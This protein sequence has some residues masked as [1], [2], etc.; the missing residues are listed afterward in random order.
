MELVKIIG[1]VIILSAYLVI[2][3]LVIKSKNIVE[4]IKEKGLSKLREIEKEL[5][6]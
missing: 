4:S 6:I 1:I 3:G 2:V 5:K